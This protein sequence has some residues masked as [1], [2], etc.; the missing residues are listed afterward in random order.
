MAF[1]KLHLFLDESPNIELQ[2]IAFWHPLL[3]RERRCIRGRTPGAYGEGY[4][5]FPWSA[6]VKGLTALLLRANAHLILESEPNTLMPQLQGGKGSLARSLDYALNKSPAWLSDMFGV[7]SV[8]KALILRLLLRSNSE[9]RR[10][11]DVALS[12]R[13]SSLTR[14]S[15]SV[16]VSADRIDDPL[17]LLALADRIDVP[18]NSFSDSHE[19]PIRENLPS[20]VTITGETAISCSQFILSHSWEQVRSHTE[21]D[22]FPPYSDKTTHLRIRDVFSKE[23]KHSLDYTD[24]FNRCSFLS[25]LKRTVENPSLTRLVDDL[26]PLVSDYDLKLLRSEQLG[27]ASSQGRLSRVLSTDQPMRVALIPSA[28]APLALFLYLKHVKGY[29]IEVTFSHVL[30]SE[31]TRL[32]LD[33]EGGQFFDLAMVAIPAGARLLSCSYPV[34]FS[35]LMVVPGSSYR[36]MASSTASGGDA[37][38]RKGNYCFLSDSPSN[39]SFYFDELQRAGHIKK[40]QVQISHMEQDEITTAFREKDPDLRT[41]LWF[42]YHSFNHIA[43]GATYL[44]TPF[45]N[46]FIGDLLFVH[47]PWFRNYEAMVCL[48]IAIRDAWLTLRENPA[49]LDGIMNILLCD[50]QYLRALHRS[51]GLHD[52]SL[53]QAFEQQLNAQEITA[54]ALPKY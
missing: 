13:L 17:Q 45:N 44:K 27:L 25:E 42:P 41:I 39:C 16:Y 40:S 23:V 14:E 47:E 31:I 18:A 49:V 4:G 54:P 53:Q 7:D 12:V 36:A 1:I 28:V 26:K 51:A 10:P 8:G 34:D 9:A 21:H 38:L 52:F 29:H 6:A 24:I 32:I 22:L 11:G 35:P 5:C 19:Q 48:D 37:R 46:S 3:D 15:I 43:N 33:G 2:R 20:K 50:P 30:C